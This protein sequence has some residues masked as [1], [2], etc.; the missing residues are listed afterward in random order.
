MKDNNKR[1]TPEVHEKIHKYTINAEPHLKNI[2]HRIS[3]DDEKIL[4]FGEGDTPTP[5]AILN[6]VSQLEQILNAK[7][8]T[9]VNLGDKITLIFN[10][11]DKNI[12]KKS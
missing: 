8:E 5:E 10:I 1:L 12:I 3:D 11:L 6:D 7:Y 2:G 4:L 9:Y